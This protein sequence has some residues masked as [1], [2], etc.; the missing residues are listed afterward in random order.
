MPV[1][2]ELPRLVEMA[3][4]LAIMGQRGVR[5][6][7]LGAIALDLLLAKA[8]GTRMLERARPEEE[9]RIRRTLEFLRKLEAEVV[10]LHSIVL[11]RKR[12]ARR[13]QFGMAP[14]VITR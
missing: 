5:P 2:L 13:A 4:E 14:A 3:Q 7:R 11:G 10:R 8:A 9:K 6:R 12:V 1:T